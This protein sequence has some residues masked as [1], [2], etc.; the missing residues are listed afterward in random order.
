[1]KVGIVTIT[2]GENY[3]N[4]LQNYALQY[5]LIKKGHKVETF[6]NLGDNNVNFIWNIKNILKRSIFYKK[7]KNEILRKKAFNNFNKEFIYFS[8]YRLSNK[9]VPKGISELYD[10]F[11]CG[12]DQ[13]WNANYKE[14]SKINFLDFIDLNKRNSFAASFGSNHIPENRKEEYSKWLKNF[15]NISVR[16]EDGKDIVKELADRQ[17]VEVLVD[18]TMLLSS[19]EWRVIS[20]KPKNLKSKKYILNYFLG[21]ITE[22]RKSEIDRIAKENNCEIINILDKKSEFY[23][24][25]PSEFLFLEDNAFL[26]CTDSFHSCVFAILFNTPFIIFDRKDDNI[27]S[28]NS[29]INTLLN[30][31]KLENRKFNK[32]IT[33]QQLTCNYKIAYNILEKER[34]KADCYIEKIFSNI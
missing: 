2:S 3:G 15:K 30:K 10:V 14:N 5:K 29:R 26:I 31:F 24:C 20:K 1:M 6:Y 32:E 22:N 13:I 11:I 23:A 8:K 33:S 16:E 9:K 19:N 21:D 17:D 28:M 34:E 7:Y 27:V 4:R 12:S 25:D 18:P